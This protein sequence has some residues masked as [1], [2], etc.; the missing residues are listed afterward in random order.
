MPRAC[1]LALVFAVSAVAAPVP[2]LDPELDRIGKVYGTVKGSVGAKLSMDAKNVLT[3]KLE[4]ARPPKKE[5]PGEEP[6]VPIPQPTGA[7]FTRPVKG[8]FTATVRFKL[9]TDLAARP[10]DTGGV[11]VGLTVEYPGGGSAGIDGTFGLTV[12]GVPP[13]MRKL[14]VPSI[15]SHTS[16]GKEDGFRGRGQ[17]GGGIS[18][19]SASILGPV[20]VR[21][22]RVGK[23]V[24]LEH[25]P[26]G[27]WEEF[28]A[29]AI[30]AAGEGKLTLRVSSDHGAET[31][32]VIEALEVK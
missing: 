2:K 7:T 18:G 19:L 3:A 14:V 15:G 21:V 27:K 6:G 1:L 28:D 25:R 16:T 11:S 23:K 4:K 12:E 13:F 22:R 32:V 5:K 24:L 31:E 8:E 29:R 30:P 26:N 10:D 20:E 9:T 17:G